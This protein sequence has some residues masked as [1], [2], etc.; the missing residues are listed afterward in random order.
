LAL[1]ARFG[2][3]RTSSPLEERGL[4]RIRL[5]RSLGR[6]EAPDAEL[7]TKSAS[8]ARGSALT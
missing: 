7:A 1:L 5:L 4:L 3:A 2:V 8:V 6:D